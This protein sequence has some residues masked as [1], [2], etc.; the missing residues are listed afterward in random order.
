MNATMLELLET[1]DLLTH[2][3]KDILQALIVL[4]VGL[5]AAPYAKK[6]I[7]YV[8]TRF[9]AP[10]RVMATAGN[11]ASIIIIFFTIMVATK[12]AG[13]DSRNIFR[14]LMAL[15]LASI[16][17]ILLIRPYL[18]SL[19]FKT[20]NLIKTKDFFGRAEAISLL[21]TRLRT[22]EGLTVFVPNRVII[23]DYL[24]N[25]HFTATR[26]IKV[27]VNIGFD[28]DLLK[29]KRTLESIMIGDP[30]VQ[31]TPRPVV[32]VLNLINGCIQL[33]G[34]CWVKN[35]DFWI[36]RCELLEKIKLRYDYEGI[37]LARP[38]M[39]LH[40]HYDTEDDTADLSDADAE[41]ESVLLNEAKM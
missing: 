16:A 40:H 41:A 37:K 18:P 22:Y 11:I 34:R 14:A 9:G 17:V 20:G 12:I 30:R 29:A 1:R 39:D 2:Y 38:Q 5:V 13:L 23:N 32:Y 28:Q 35:Q 15:L 19:P 7:K 27:D 10:Q 4:I 8:L 33:G 6:G 21:N 3:G 31:V 36:T 24:I 25:Y 26:R